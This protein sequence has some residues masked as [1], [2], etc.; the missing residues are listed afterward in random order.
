MNRY[1]RQI[2]LPQLGECG[3]QKLAKSRVLVIGAGGLGCALLPYLAASGIGA[4]GIIDGDKIEESNLHR[5]VLYTAN[6]IDKSK[7]EI[8]KIRLEQQNP[9]CVVKVFP[10]YLNGHNALN[11]FSDYDILVDATDRI[12]V[13]YLINDA[14]VLT[15]KPVVYGSIHRF[16]GQVSVFNF[17]NGPT[18]R[19][20]F[21][22][23]VEA[24]SCAEAG[25]LG[26]AVGLIGLLQAQEVI[27][28]ILNQGNV[29]SGQLLIYNCLS[30]NQESFQ[31]TKKNEPEITQ[32][33]YNNEHLKENF[34]SL[35]FQQNMLR[36]G[37]FLD[38]REKQ[39]QPRLP[40]D[41]LIEIP[42]NKLKENWQLLNPEETHYIFCQSGKRALAA[43]EY[44]SKSG[45]VKVIPLKTGAPEIA[46]SVKQLQLSR[47][48]Y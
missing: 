43:A 6:D 14:A 45:I 23:A 3:Q 35:N 4:I 46:E 31:F 16:E 44:L 26:T 18:Y 13:R 19:C 42:L 48:S 27:K 21:P 32:E 20:L 24:P 9:D 47:R 33:F 17:E 36:A 7:V 10:E 28:I 41:G 15:H 22:K 39:E 2:I 12:K 37:V 29:L 11:F 40:I 1:K 5:Q 38:V 34:Q 25:V 8:A 30:A